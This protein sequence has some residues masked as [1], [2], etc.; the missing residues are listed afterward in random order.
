[1][2]S[3]TTTSNAITVGCAVA[4]V[5]GT[6]SLFLWRQRRRKSVVAESSNFQKNQ[7]ALLEWGSTDK[8]CF[9][10]PIIRLNLEKLMP[11]L[12]TIGAIFG[13]RSVD[14]IRITTKDGSIVTLQESASG[15][16]AAASSCQLQTGQQYRVTYSGMDVSPCSISDIFS[17]LGGNEEKIHKVSKTFYSSIW[18]D[19]NSS[20]AN[21]R[22]HFVHSAKSP[23][24][25]AD[26]QARWLIEMWGGP[27]RYLEKHGHA[28]V[29]SRMLSRHASPSRMTYAHA[30]TWLKYMN[31][32]V[33]SVYGDDELVKLVL[34]LYWR[35]FFGFFPMTEEE[36]IGIR[37]L[38]LGEKD[39]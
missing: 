7:V 39:K 37:K 15:Q 30:C 2:V 25:A 8:E 28:L 11:T 21:F 13:L 38:A 12:E 26:N 4:V 3:K 33:T 27:K 9:C 17:L 18:N 19:D 31:A 5:V 6:V 10:R 14:K 35:H 1:M 32:A 20:N 16:A 36:R 23:E 34:G 24:A 22:S 29:G